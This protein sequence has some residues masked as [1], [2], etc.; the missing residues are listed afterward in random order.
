MFTQ[1]SSTLFEICGWLGIFWGHH[2]WMYVRIRT[3]QML[4]PDDLQPASHSQ[5]TPVQCT[6]T[7]SAC[8]TSSSCP[9]PIILALYCCVVPCLRSFIREYTAD[10]SSVPARH[11]NPARRINAWLH[12]H[13]QPRTLHW[14][15]RRCTNRVLEQRKFQSSVACLR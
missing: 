1:V 6:H 7:A 2:W 11:G 3:A 10:D 12:R 13:L 14:L 4:Y 9:N 15:L 8:I 5:H